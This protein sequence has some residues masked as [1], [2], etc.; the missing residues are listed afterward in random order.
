[1]KI[2][3]VTYTAKAD[4]SEQNQANIKNVMADLREIN[5][6]GLFYHA[7]VSAEGS[8]FTHTA[9]FTSP[10]EEQILLTL[11]SFKT[12]QEQLKANGLESHPKQEVQ[13]L[14]GSSRD[15]L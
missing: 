4:Y 12:F 6:P 5:N 3:K 15:V 8:N 1:M 9:F 13:N 2:V 11:P 10:E 14:V 7:C